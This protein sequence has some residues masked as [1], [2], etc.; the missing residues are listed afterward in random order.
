[1]RSGCP[2]KDRL[3]PAARRRPPGCPPRPTRPGEERALG[4]EP[5]SGG[6]AFT[7]E[8]GAGGCQSPSPVQP[9]GLRGRELGD[10]WAPGS[11]ALGSSDK[12]KPFE[13]VGEKEPDKAFVILF[14]ILTTSPP[15]ADPWTP[16]RPLRPPRS[17]LPRWPPQPLPLSGGLLLCGARFPSRG[18]HRQLFPALESA[19]PPPPPWLHSDGRVGAL[20]VGTRGSGARSGVLPYLG[21]Q[22][23]TL[24]TPRHAGPAARAALTT[25]VCWATRLGSSGHRDLRPAPSPL[26]SRIAEL[27]AREDRVGSVGGQ[28][29]PQWSSGAPRGARFPPRAQEAVRWIEGG[30]GSKPR[31]PPGKP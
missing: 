8:E 11:A 13:C 16:R 23:H 15:P 2:G 19:P 29:R 12:F 18:R 3:L 25:G 24:P 5:N 31:L 28:T 4:S 7:S 26:R 9:A 1:M 6:W 21:V 17:R 27:K 20:A 14:I 10:P 30:G 22:T